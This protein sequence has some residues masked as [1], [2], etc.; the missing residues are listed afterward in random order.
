MKIVSD[1]IYLAAAGK[2]GVGDLYLPSDAVPRGTVLAIHGGGWN[3]LNK[4]SF[5]GVAEFLCECGFAV[6]NINYRLLDAG[7]WPL[8]GDDCLKA[9][10]FLLSGMLERFT[11]AKCSRILIVGAS[12]GGH[13]ALMTGLRLPP[14]SVGG[15][16]SISG[17]DD[18]N[19]F[20]S[21]EDRHVFFGRTPLQKEFDAANP[22][23]YIRF[24]QPP[25]LLTHSR[26]DSVAPFA[27]AET[28]LAQCRKAGA[29]AELYEY[30]RNES[31][32]SHCIWI[33]GT[34]PHRLYPDLEDVIRNFLELREC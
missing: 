29:V 23:H 25:V 15:I 13:L 11:G 22:I 16:V 10:E 24:G 14:E 26:F 17:V 5:A 32:P 28:F 21:T 34:N 18:L 27:A 12:A 31:P 4:S 3:A 7:P 8:C 6:F 9:A 20:L 2:R 30:D 33:P 19:S 1:Q